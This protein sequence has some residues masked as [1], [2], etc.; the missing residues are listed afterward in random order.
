MLALNIA[1]IVIGLIAVTTA[2][3]TQRAHT[4]PD[5]SSPAEYNDPPTQKAPRTHPER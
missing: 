1:L 4:F 2:I 3:I 5:Q